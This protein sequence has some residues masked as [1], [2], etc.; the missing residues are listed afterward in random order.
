MEPAKE[1]M[2]Y[3]ELVE[4]RNALSTVK[5]DFE[6]TEIIHEDYDGVEDITM[7]IPLILP[8]NSVPTVVKLYGRRIGCGKYCFTEFMLYPKNIQEENYEFMLS[9]VGTA[10]DTLICG[11]FLYLG[12]GL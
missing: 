2:T 1:D 10:L 12:T 4:E 3:N 9:Q 11:R 8:D 5:C 7:I 6:K